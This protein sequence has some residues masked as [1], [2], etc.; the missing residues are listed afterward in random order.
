MNELDGDS[1]TKLNT[2]LN[3]SMV[4]M[5]TTTDNETR[6]PRSSKSI[7]INT[8]VQPARLSNGSPA[9]RKSILKKTDTRNDERGVE[10]QE[11]QNVENDREIINTTNNSRVSMSV[12]I[13]SR[14]HN[15]NIIYFINFYH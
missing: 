6:S 7:K 8:K 3:R 4:L 9:Q 14:P 11:A 2:Q 15:V 5:D 10:T 13:A 12:P 1:L